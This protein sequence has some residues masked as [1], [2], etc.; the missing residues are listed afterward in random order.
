MRSILGYA[1]AVEASREHPGTRL[2]RTARG[3]VEPRPSHCP[4]CG[5]RLGPHKVLVGVAQCRCA[6]SHRT[7]FCRA[8]EFT[9]YSPALTDGCL[10]LAMDER[11]M[12]KTLRP[13]SVDK[14]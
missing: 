3:W 12:R 11:N 8:C 10:L 2:R 4:E 14:P 13:E 9:L 7:F 5:A 6:Q 1:G